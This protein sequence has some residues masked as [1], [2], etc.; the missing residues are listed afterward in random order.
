MSPL[1][2]PFPWGSGLIIGLSLLVQVVRAEDP[3]RP[4]IVGIMTDDVAYAD[5][6]CYGSKD[7]RTPHIDQLAK[8]GVRLTDAYSNGIV[9]SPTRAAFITGRYPQRVG[10]DW[11]VDYGQKDLGLSP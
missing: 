2:R 6:G 9:C 11:V 10:F 7:I 4:N 5:L 3:R 8:Q 1:G